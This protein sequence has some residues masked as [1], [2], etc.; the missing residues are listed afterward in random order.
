M[1]KLFFLLLLLP[2][3]CT[4]QSN[5]ERAFRMPLPDGVEIE[6]DTIREGGNTIIYAYFG[7]L[8]CPE[9]KYADFCKKLGLKKADKEYVMPAPG[10][11]SLG[12]YKWWDPPLPIGPIIDLRS[13]YYKG[14]EEKDVLDGWRCGII[15]QYDHGNIYLHKLGTDR[16]P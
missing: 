4:K 12:K 5:F 2:L 7:K 6:N 1:R 15:A 14:F 10:G 9:E 11:T 16:A 13:T 3:A 8:K